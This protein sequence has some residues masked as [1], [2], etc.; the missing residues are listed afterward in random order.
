MAGGYRL[1]Q[2]IHGGP[3]PG[4]R[5]PGR[6]RKADGRGQGPR[7]GILQRR[8]RSPDA[9][10]QDLPGQTTGGRAHRLFEPVLPPLPTEEWRVDQ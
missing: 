2:A 9:A 4:G 8:R 1:S 5:A 6:S 10:A 7:L 3:T